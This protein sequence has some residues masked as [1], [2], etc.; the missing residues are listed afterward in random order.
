MSKFS[1]FADEN[2]FVRN[3]YTEQ[4]LVC[5]PSTVSSYLYIIY[6]LFIDYVVVYINYNQ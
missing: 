5:L 2:E 4:S 3:V 1:N 6:R